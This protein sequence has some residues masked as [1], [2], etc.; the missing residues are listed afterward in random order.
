MNAS[1]LAMIRE[2][3]TGLSRQVSAGVRSARDMSV[4]FAT[5]T[6]LAIP[7]VA[8][9][10]VLLHRLSESQAHAYQIYTLCGEIVGSYRFSEQTENLRDLLTAPELLDSVVESVA[11][12]GT[13]LR[14]RV[15]I[16]SV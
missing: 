11:P 16:S 14:F 6:T 7:L 3:I 8:G 1:D 13:G 10:R 4:T 15:Q 2:A 9:D 5:S 12:H